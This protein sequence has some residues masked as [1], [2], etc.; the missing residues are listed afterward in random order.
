MW[1]DLSNPSEVDQADVAN[2][3]TEALAKYVAGGVYAFMQPE[4][5]FSIVW[6]MEPDVVDKL[7]EGIDMSL[8]PATITGKSDDDSVNGGKPT[9]PAAAKGELGGK[10]AV[11]EKA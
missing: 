9:D 5:Y 11:G 6:K 7:V 8:L 2:T 10:S 4:E 3:M 1:P